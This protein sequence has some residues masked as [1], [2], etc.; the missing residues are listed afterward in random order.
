MRC[1]YC[2]CED[3]KVVDSRVAEQLSIRR[4]RECLKCKRRFTTYERVES[5]PLIVVKKD[6]T[7]QEF[8]REKLLRGL[9]HACRKRPVSVEQMEQIADEVEN[10]FTLQREVSV[11][12]I[13]DAVMDKLRTLDPVA[14]VRFAS[15]Y[16]EF[17]DAES[18]IE[19]LKELKNKSD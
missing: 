16:K 12:K 13:G 17:K 9:M 11:R 14:Y 10:M 8:S 6:D 1:I 3:S 7:R 5:V 19:E 18:F 15:V 4:R 2:G